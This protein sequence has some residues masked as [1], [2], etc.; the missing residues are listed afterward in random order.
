MPP[1]MVARPMFG[2]AARAPPSPASLERGERGERAARR[3]SR[4]RRRRRARASRSAACGAVTP[5]SVS[6]VLVEAH[7]RDDR[8]ARD[9]A[10]GRDRVDELLQVEER[11]E[12]EQVGAAALEDCAPARRT[13]R[14][15]TRGA[16]RLAERPDRAADEDVAA[17]DLARL[18]RELH[19][20]R[21]DPL[22][23]VLEEVR[24]ELPAVGAERVRLDQLGA[25]VDEAHVQRDDGLRRAQVR[26]LGRAQPRH[27]G[28]QQRAHAAVGDDR[29]ALA[30]GVSR[31]GRPR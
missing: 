11:L 6:R 8:Q 30:S 9:A 18:A 7:Q 27:G 29:R 23:L 13:A 28:R 4:R 19:A 21:V 15:A 22:E 5:P 2:S 10:D 24:R 31:T 14:G 3:G 25:G 16:R 26:L 1:V 20:G 17:G 12:H